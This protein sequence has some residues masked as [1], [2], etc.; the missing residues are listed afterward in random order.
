MPKPSEVIADARS[1]A[2]PVIQRFQS[3]RY[4]PPAVGYKQT[5]VLFLLMCVVAGGLFYAGKR[6]ERSWWRAQIAAQ[7]AAVDTVMRQLGAEAPDLD[8]RLIKEWVRDNDEKLRAAER[9]M[10][11]AARDAESARRRLADVEQARA[12][13]PAL[14]PPVVDACRPLPAH[15]LRN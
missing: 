12:V 10:A 6:S 14:P 1:R 11:T 2:A 9:K 8:E 5:A 3:F 7:S 4:D 15:C 13:N